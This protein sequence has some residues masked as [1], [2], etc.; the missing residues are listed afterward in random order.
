ME[1]FEITKKQ[2]K[3]L[4]NASE[5]NVQDMLEDWFPNIFQHQVGFYYVNPDFGLAMYKVT[6]IEKGDVF[7]YGLDHLGVWRN[8]CVFTQL[9]N[10]FSAHLATHE[11]V[12][13]ALTKEAINRG[14]VK[15][16]DFISVFYNERHHCKKGVLD[17]SSFNQKS[18][19]IIYLDGMRI[20]TN[21]TWATI[22]KPQE[23]TLQQIADKFEIPIEQLRIKDK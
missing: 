11:E 22:I 17:F 18:N 3:I 21:G 13:T 19:W 12:Q 7:A 23:L 8:E 5:R 9:E 16:C 6:K 10:K 4:H 15:G 20:F 2:I 1:K 14:F